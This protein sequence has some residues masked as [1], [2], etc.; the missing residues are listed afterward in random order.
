MSRWLRIKHGLR[1]MFAATRADADLRD[2]LHHHLDLESKKLEARGLSPAA[3]RREAERRLGGALSTREDTRDARGWLWLDDLRRDVG[4]ALRLTRRAPGFTLAVVA[5]LGLAIGAATAI[6]S[7]VTGVLLRPTPLTAFD[8]LGVLW[9]T[10]RRSGTTREPMSWPDFRDFRDRSQGFAALAGLSSQEMSLIDGANDPVRLTVV[11]TTPNYFG[12]V[13]A[14]PLLGRFYASTDDALPPRVAVISEHLWRQR[15]GA[16]P[17]MVGR[18]I[19]LDAGVVTVI[20][21]APAGIDFGLDQIHAQAAYHGNYAGVGEV[22]VWAPIE[23][24]FRDSPRDTHPILALGRLAPGATFAAAQSEAVGIATDLERTYP[25]SNTARGIHLESLDAVVFGPVR[26][27]LTL[28]VL[29]AALVLIVGFVNGANLLLARGASR[30]REVAVRTALGAGSRRL[31]RQFA[32]ECVLLGVAGGVVG[33]VLAKVGLATLLR[34]AP[35]DLPRLDQIRL[36]GVMLAGSWA[37]SVAIG[38]GFGLVPAW[39]ARRVD[40]MAAMRAD[41]RTVAGG[42][43]RLRRALVVAELSGSVTL[44]VA[45]VLL[46]RSLAIIVATGP[47]FGTAGLLKAQYQLPAAR[48]PQD[49]RQFPRWAEVHRFTETLLHEASSL[50]GVV[51]VAAANAHPLDAGFTNSFRIVGREAESAAWP[52]ISVR[53]ITPGYPVAVGLAIVEGRTFTDGDDA[54]APLVALIN[55]TAATR[56][57]PNGSALGHEIQWWGMARRIVGVVTDERIR[58]VTEAVPPAVYAAM[59]QVPSGSGVLVVRATSDP[60]AVIEPLRA[61]FRRLDPELAVYGL[62]PLAATVLGSVATRRFAMVVIGAFAAV[63]IALALIGIYGVLSYL[64]A[65]RTREI[66][67]RVALGATRNDVRALVLRSGLPMVGLGL[68]IGLVGALMASRLLAPLLFRIAPVDPSSYLMV[69]VGVGLA[70]LA[71]MWLPIRA[72]SRIEPIEALRVDG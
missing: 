70:A 9:Q 48:Y 54:N 5:T 33:V 43:G 64:A 2:E 32:V 26:P 27:V 63:T 53:S 66:G 23:A 21:V 19:R 22:D 36:D 14:T 8:Q 55:Q 68:T 59:A 13:G 61:L 12:L 37:L 69:A 4:I 6:A 34:W 35:P 1:A 29:A 57:F 71:A 28:L 45:A 25:G 58:G 56:F 50:S 15:F 18:T 49:V 40:P 67:V 20:G 30:V 42:H 11:L 51:A 24:L 17:S 60:S 10:D 39:Q 44:V 47:G 62:E 31:G 65:S 16:D 46:V 3:A 41:S 38:L 7:V 72:A 52:E